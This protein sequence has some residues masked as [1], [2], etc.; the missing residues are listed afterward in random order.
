[1]GRRLS[2]P[3]YCD[4]FLDRHGRPRSY[5]RYSKQ[6]PRIALPGL[7]WSPEFMAAHAVALQGAAPLSGLPLSEPIPFPVAPRTTPLPQ[8]QHYCNFCGKAQEEVASLIAGPGPIFICSECVA[9]CHE[10]EQRRL[11]KIEEGA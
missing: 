6:A 1:M 11:R 2:L 9:L 3:P 10:I 4:H 5:F 8:S 7:P